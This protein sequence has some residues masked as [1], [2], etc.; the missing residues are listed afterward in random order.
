M[1]IVITDTKTNKDAILVSRD[2]YPFGSKSQEKLS[3]GYDFIFSRKT[4]DIP[5][6]LIRALEQNGFSKPVE[7]GY[8]TYVKAVFAVKRVRI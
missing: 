2:E 1:Q 4:R 3:E 6:W 7:I 8:T 5:K